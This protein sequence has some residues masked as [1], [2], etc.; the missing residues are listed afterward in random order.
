MGYAV[1]VGGGDDEVDVELRRELEKLITA[2]RIDAVKRLI[3]EQRPDL[4]RPLSN[5]S[6]ALAS[7]SR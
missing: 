3:E 4:A 1:L 5:M 7:T 6:L 2:A